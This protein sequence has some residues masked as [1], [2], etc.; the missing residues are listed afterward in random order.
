MP[1]VSPVEYCKIELQLV[2]TTSLVTP[3]VESS[4]VELYLVSSKS[5]VAV[6]IE[7]SRVELQ[8]VSGAAVSLLLKLSL[9]QAFNLT[10]RLLCDK[11][12]RGKQ[13]S[14]LWEPSTENT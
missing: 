14:I 6:V 4:M 3:V 1:L 7:R 5:L 11:S 9:I 2:S 13:A 12:Q 8:L 10:E